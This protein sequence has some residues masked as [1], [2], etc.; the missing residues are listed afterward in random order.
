MLKKWIKWK[1]LAIFL[2]RLSKYKREMEQNLDKKFEKEINL[3]E[4]RVKEKEKEIC[5]LK[6][7]LTKHSELDCEL[8][9]K[10]KN[11]EDK[12]T[13]FMN[14]IKKLEEEKKLIQ[15]ELYLLEKTSTDTDDYSKQLQAKVNKILYYK[16]LIIIY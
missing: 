15:N 6:K 5:E 7:N 1:D 9:K 16:L 12:E 8:S 2:N 14:S 4:T 3:L 11:F 10:I 13:N